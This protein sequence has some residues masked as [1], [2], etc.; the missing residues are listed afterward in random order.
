MSLNKIV[1]QA[2]CTAF[3]VL[4]DL[5]Q[6]VEV[7]IKATKTFNHSTGVAETTYEDGVTYR[8]FM[9]HKKQRTYGTQ[10]QVTGETTITFKGNKDL[11]GC[12]YLCVI[13]TYNADGTKKDYQEWNVDSFHQDPIGATTTVIVSRRGRND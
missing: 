9:S 2:V 6:P 3:D 13:F 1:S 12:D 5:S 10:D 8:G 11:T 7:V 4:E